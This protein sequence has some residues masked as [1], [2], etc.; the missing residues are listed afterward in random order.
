MVGVTILNRL[1]LLKLEHALLAPSDLECL[2]HTLILAGTMDVALS[3]N[4]PLQCSIDNP[5]GYE[6]KLPALTHVRLV[7]VA[8]LHTKLLLQQDVREQGLEM[9]LSQ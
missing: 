4:E 1:I 5:L 8:V 7:L 3:T 2:H 9:E 6:I